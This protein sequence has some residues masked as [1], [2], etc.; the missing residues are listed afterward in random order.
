MA[1]PA[2]LVTGASGYLGQF[3]VEWYAGKGWK[4]GCTYRT[5]EAPKF[6]SGV[7]VFRVD[8]GSGEGLHEGCDALG[9]LAAV[10]NCA[11]QAAPAACEGEGEAAARA[12]NV[13]QP[14]LVH[15]STDHV[16]DGG[17]SF[18]REDAEL[19]P[20]NTYGRTK[21]DGEAEVALRWRRHVILR[22]SIIFGPPPPN[23]IRRGQFLQF[24]DSCLAAQKPSTFFTDEWRTPTYVKDLVAACAAAVDAC[25]ALPAAPPHARVFN[26][27]GPAR[28]N[29]L[30]MALAVAEVRGHDPALALP[31]S[32]AAVAR[33]CATPADISMDTSAVEAVLGVR[34]TPFTEALRQ[35][36]GGGG[37]GCQPAHAAAG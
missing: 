29:R 16:Y 9:P 1:Q 4:V 11:A 34:M 8:L 27:G 19:R 22:P 23:P 13:P 3:V 20:V 14:V 30:D 28:I 25:D 7:Q 18:Y 37:G 10:I 35:I 24:V 6:G 12:V 17:S 36:F 32:A 2:V 31:G 15:I 26:V 33:T 5:G 21:A